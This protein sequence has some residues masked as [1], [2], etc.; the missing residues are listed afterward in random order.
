MGT[1]CGEEVPCGDAD[2]QRSLCD[3]G[4]TCV[5]QS[6][7]PWT[8]RNTAECPENRICDA[9]LRCVLDTAYPAPDT[10]CYCAAAPWGGGGRR[11]LAVV[12]AAFAVL[13]AVLRR[14][15]R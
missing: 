2:V 1:P 6:C 12:L 9:T 4:G 11:L 5:P 3:E 8:C 13:T 15:L 10:G 14:R 7:M